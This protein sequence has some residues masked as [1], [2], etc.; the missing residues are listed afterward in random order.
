MSFVE[1]HSDHGS[2]PCGAVDRFVRNIV[3]PE[4][5]LVSDPRL[6]HTFMANR[7]LFGAYVEAR[8]RVTDLGADVINIHRLLNIHHRIMN[9]L[10]A[11]ITRV[12]QQGHSMQ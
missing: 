3:A 12:E 5:G 11:M 4:T 1:F 8:D 9:L 2:L 6:A 10:D 7:H